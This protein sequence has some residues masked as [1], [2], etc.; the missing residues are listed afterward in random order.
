MTPVVDCHAHVGTQPAAFLEEMVV[1]FSRAAGRPVPP[2]IHEPFDGDAM[3]AEYRAAG[4]D[5]VLIYAVA[6]DEPRVFGRTGYPRVEAVTAVSNEE[7]AEIHARFPDLTVPV[8]A[9]NPR[10]QG[11]REAARL[12][13]HAVEEL[14]GRA[15]KLY[16]TYNHYAPDDR[17][18][19]W[20]L[21]ETVQELG[22][23]LIVHQSWTTTVHA[24][25]ALQR[26]AQLD[27]VALDFPDLVI[28]AAHL[29]VPWVDECMCLVAKHDNVHV[30]TS[31]WTVLEPPAEILRQL[32]RCH[33][34]GCTW[35]RIMWGTDYPMVGPAEGLALFRDQLPAAAARTG[36][37]PLP[38]EAL[39]LMLGGNAA[40]LYG[41]AA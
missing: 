22:V 15:I 9:V 33:R 13:R 12:A 38:D 20:P 39:D 18:L 23:P 35:D 8:M 27:A 34:Y 36:L 5:R 14:G 32:W 29:G 10:F 16:P 6:A 37:D 25:M 26:P 2:Q 7:V 17:E 30:D 31:F 24:P 41:I 1:P 4:V 40:R 19:C 3:A 28:V 11:A 21:Y